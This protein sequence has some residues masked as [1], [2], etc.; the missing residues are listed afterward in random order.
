MP[1]FLWVGQPPK[2]WSKVTKHA[3]NDVFN[4]IISIIII[5]IIIVLY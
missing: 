1:T 4:D 3:A 2:R 5:I